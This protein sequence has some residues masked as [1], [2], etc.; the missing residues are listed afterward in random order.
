MVLTPWWKGGSL[1]QLSKK[2]WHFSNHT[3]SPSVLTSYPSSASS[4]QAMTMSFK[5]LCS[6]KCHENQSGIN[7]CSGERRWNP[8]PRVTPSL[9]G[10][11]VQGGHFQLA[12]RS[13][14]HRVA[15]IVQREEVDGGKKTPQIHWKTGF[16][17]S[18]VNTSYSVHLN[19]TQISSWTFPQLYHWS[20][21]ISHRQ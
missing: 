11:A 2:R 7:Q 3:I 5:K 15:F 1:A 19:P 8:P 12:T 20:I 17:S 10:L 14:T 16:C 9:A 6:S 13:V 18:S 21:L 4:N